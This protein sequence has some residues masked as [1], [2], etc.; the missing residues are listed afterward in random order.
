MAQ[1]T[2]IERRLM[3]VNPSALDLP[4]FV[5]FK[6]NEYTQQ[7]SFIGQ[8]ILLNPLAMIKKDITN[9]VRTMVR[10]GLSMLPY[11]YGISKT[12]LRKWGY[13]PGKEH[14]AERK[15][16]RADTEEDIKIR[17]PSGDSKRPGDDD[18]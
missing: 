6:T 4:K 3:C 1:T 9:Y 5:R 7:T 2:N 12:Q 17:T 13:L 18:Q 8:G 14:Y 15:R 10:R 11:T 16:E